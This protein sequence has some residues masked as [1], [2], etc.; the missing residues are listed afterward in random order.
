MAKTWMEK[1]KEVFET[2]EQV[3]YSSPFLTPDGLADFFYRIVPEKNSYGEVETV[4]AIARDITE[5]KRAEREVLDLKDQLAQRAT[6]RYQ[7][8]FNSIDEG[9]CI[10]EKVEGDSPLDFRFIEVNPAFGIQAGLEDVVGRTLREVSPNVS[11]EWLMTYDDV[12]TRGKEI[13]L[14]RGMSAS[15]KML[16]VYAFRVK[17]ETNRRVGVVFRDITERKKAEQDVLKLK[18]ELAQK[19]PINTCPFSIQLTKVFIL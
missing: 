6:D 4:L 7:T 11:E 18:D 12:V 19:L 2:G 5:L 17:D 10:L 9:F 15:E 13:R 1:L 8:L 16:E 14:E 3:A